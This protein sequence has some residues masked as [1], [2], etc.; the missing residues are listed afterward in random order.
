MARIHHKRITLRELILARKLADTLGS[1]ERALMLLPYLFEPRPRRSTRT[2]KPWSANG[3]A[4][5]P[6]EPASESNL[7][8][9][10]TEPERPTIRAVGEPRVVW[11]PEASAHA[12][13]GKAFTEWPEDVPDDDPAIESVAEA[14]VFESPRPEPV[15]GDGTESVDD[16]VRAEGG[17]ADRD[18]PD[19]RRVDWLAGHSRAAGDEPGRPEQ[20]VPRPRGESDT[21]CDLEVRERAKWYP[22]EDTRGDEY[23]DVGYMPSPDEIAARM[24]EI[25]EGRVV[26]SGGKSG[27]R[28][29]AR[30]RIGY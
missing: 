9:P 10:A 25:R 24:R 17:Q 14:A 2:T 18:V 11:R 30:P 4:N 15:D 19:L 3:S 26:A 29:P 22:C 6:S 8:S 13:F 16:D 7:P 20:E 23:R 28:M 5:K 21:E 12:F 1:I 27:K